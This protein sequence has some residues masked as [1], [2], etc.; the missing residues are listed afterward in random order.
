M[1]GLHVIGSDGA[2]VID[3]TRSSD[4]REP[5]GPIALE[6]LG[7]YLLTSGTAALD[8]SDPTIAQRLQPVLNAIAASASL[9]D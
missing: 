1:S 6:N 4:R 8:L 5:G 9:R 3:A 2:T 7:F